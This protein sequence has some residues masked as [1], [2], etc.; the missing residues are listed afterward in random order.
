M[1]WCTWSTRRTYALAA[2][3]FVGQSS[4]NVNTMLL[5]RTPRQNEPNN[6][7]GTVSDFQ[8]QFFW[9]I[10]KWADCIEYPR[11][12]F[13]GHL[14]MG[15]LHR[16]SKNSFLGHLQNGWLHRI[17]KNS[18][19]GSSTNGLTASNIQEQFFWVIYKWTDCIGYQRRVFQGHLQMGWLHRIS[20][21][22]FPGSTTNG[23]TASVLQG[24]FLCV[25]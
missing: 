21:N 4:V 16:I 13:L 9:V 23:L 24:Q 22:S 1:M 20:K 7:S 3:F 18:F 19:S 5:A 10:Y 15:R 14:Q 6:I 25:N 8:E 11:T 12:F 17:S 2:L